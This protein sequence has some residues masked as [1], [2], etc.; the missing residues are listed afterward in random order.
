[1]DTKM[2]TVLDRLQGMSAVGTLEFQRG[3]SLFTI[4]KCLPTDFAF[5]LSPATGI[6]V[7]VLM[8]SPTERTY[9]IY[10]DSAGF[11][12]LGFDRFDS[13]AVAKEVILVPELPVLLNEWLDE[14]K[15]IGK[16][17]L[18]FGV[19]EFTMSPLFE[20]DESAD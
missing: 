7:D 19:V 18:I 9:G 20:R 3:S 2:L 17:L 16:E 13:L 14:W 5:E 6:I 1:M 12:F 10:R 11:T 4:D 15:F 8:G